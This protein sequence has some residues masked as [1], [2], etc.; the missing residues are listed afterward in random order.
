[1]KNLWR[2]HNVLQAGCLASI[3]LLLS[4]QPSKAFEIKPIGPNGGAYDKSTNVIEIKYLT[5]SNNTNCEN[6][7]S[8]L[9]KGE[10]QP[11]HEAITRQAYLRVYGVTLPDGWRSPLIGGVVWNDD[12]EQLIRRAWYYDGLKSINTFSQRI[13]SRKPENKL[14]IRTHYGDLQF[15]HFMRPKINGKSLNDQDTLIQVW[16]WIENTYPVAS[17]N[18]AANTL[19]AKTYYNNYFSKIGCGKSSLESQTK[20]CIVLDVFDINSYFRKS[21]DIDESVKWLAS[22]TILHIIQ[23]SYSASHTHRN[24]STGAIESLYTYNGEKD[25]CLSD[26][27]AESNRRSIEQAIVASTDFLQ[28]LKDRAEWSEVQTHLE[29]YLGIRQK[30]KTETQ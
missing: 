21:G 6:V 29:K 2:R 25:H 3:F 30:R 20:P 9:A 17:G 14:T 5:D 12:P 15:L 16:D 27:G 23:D 28:L 11:I 26:I 22:G 24:E 13:K 8:Y 18:V 19:R 7:S 4:L 10:N 1:M